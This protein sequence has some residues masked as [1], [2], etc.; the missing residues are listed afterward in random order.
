MEMTRVKLP[1]FKGKP[2]IEMPKSVPTAN[3]LEG[4]FGKAVHSEYKGRA[5]RDYGDASALK[6]LSYSDGVAKGSNPFAVV[7][8]N[9]IV[10]EEG[11]RT[12]TPA[13]LE[14]IL[15]IGALP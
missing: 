10:R 7:L 14:R 1:E 15:R 12:A 9:Q 13:D 6:V 11:L 5:E 3:F 4:D 8:V 2:L